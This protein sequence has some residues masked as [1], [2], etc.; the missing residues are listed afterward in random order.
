MSGKFGL[1]LF[2]IFGADQRLLIRWEFVIIC[3]E[4]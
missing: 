2:L 3:T 4:S 1:D